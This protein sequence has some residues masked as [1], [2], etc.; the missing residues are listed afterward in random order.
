[1]PL[2]EQVAQ[3]LRDRIQ[4]KH[5]VGRVPSILGLVQEFGVSHKTA[6]HALRVLADEGTI[7]AVRGKGFYVAR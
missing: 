3:A 6:A 7:V 5:I 4:K 2:Y 1:M